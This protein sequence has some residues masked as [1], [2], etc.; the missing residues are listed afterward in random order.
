VTS[1]AATYSNMAGTLALVGRAVTLV[2]AKTGLSSLWF[3]VP[4]VKQQ[5]AGRC[6]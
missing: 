2:T 4:N 3:A 6:T 1:Q 5:A